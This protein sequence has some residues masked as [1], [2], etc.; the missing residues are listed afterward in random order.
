MDSIKSLVTGADPL[1][2]FPAGPPDGETELTGMLT[3]IRTFSDTGNAKVVNLDGARK[4]RRAIAAGLLAMTAAAVTAGIVV[5]GNLRLPEAT[6]AGPA[7]SGSPSSPASTQEV[8]TPASSTAAGPSPAQT[9]PVPT[10]PGPPPVVPAAPQA[11]AFTSGD[12]KVS[13]KLPAGWT[14]VEEPAG[15]PSYPSSVVR[16][17]NETGETMSTL[18][19]SQGG[20]LGGACSGPPAP[21]SVLDRA[22]V[23][24]A[25]QPWAQGRSV[26][27]GYAIIDE[28]ARG[29]KIHTVVG[30]LDAG[31]LP[32]GDT[33]C[34]FYAAVSTSMGMLSFADA[35]QV[36][37]GGTGPGFDSVAEA[38]AYMQTAEYQNLKAM[39]T[40]LE[41]NN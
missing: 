1:N 24:S 38:R 35:V 13:F 33:A 29:G 5:A 16:V 39:I 26:E 34:M 9:L 23:P 18:Q 32:K 22:A 30:L 8:P 19:L 37:V 40:S 20:G 6:P 31:S 28:T 12:G 4:R 2:D 14:A 36:S 11:T 21:F 27:F 7:V 41:L 25:T 3:G 17:Y 10:L 15:T